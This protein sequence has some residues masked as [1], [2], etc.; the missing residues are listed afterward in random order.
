LDDKGDA[1][2]GVEAAKALVAADVSVAIA[3]LNPA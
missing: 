1:T 3:H 2:A